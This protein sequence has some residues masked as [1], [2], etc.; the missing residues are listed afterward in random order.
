MQQ[1]KPPLHYDF[2]QQQFIEK[3]SRNGTH[4]PYFAL[5]NRLV[6]TGT[7]F[8]LL[9]RS[10]DGLVQAFG[11]FMTSAE[12][13]NLKQRFARVNKSLEFEIYAPY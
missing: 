9:V 11:T 5:L 10:W 2:I 3:F 8:T 1:Q 12:A 13:E 7:K 4:T 6:R